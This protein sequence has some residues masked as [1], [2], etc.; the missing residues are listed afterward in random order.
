[1]NVDT[2]VMFALLRDQKRLVSECARPGAWSLEV[3]DLGV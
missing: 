2:F 1:M 3:A